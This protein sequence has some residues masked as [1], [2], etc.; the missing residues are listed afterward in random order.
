VKG[1]PKAGNDAKAVVR[2]APA[3]LDTITFAFP[4]HK[5]M[6]LKALLFFHSPLKIKRK[7]L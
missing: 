7:S 4:D 6:I 5:E 2:V 3:E 1:E